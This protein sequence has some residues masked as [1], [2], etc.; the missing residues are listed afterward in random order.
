MMILEGELGE[1]PKKTDQ[2]PARSPGNPPAKH[3][4]R[5]AN[6]DDGAVT[7]ERLNVE[8]RRTIALRVCATARGLSCWVPCVKRPQEGTQRNT[9]KSHS[10]STLHCNKVCDST[11]SGFIKQVALHQLSMPWAC[12]PNL[13]AEWM[14]RTHS[15]KQTTSL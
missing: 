8:E 3:P 15:A 6:S 5:I 13:Q 1:L 14:S 12:Q 10:I 9:N 4:I 11:A 2:D 7:S